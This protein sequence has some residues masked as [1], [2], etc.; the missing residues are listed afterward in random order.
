MGK[1][2]IARNEQFLLFPTVFSTR[3][4]EILGCKRCLFAVRSMPFS[5]NIAHEADFKIVK[6]LRLKTCE[7]K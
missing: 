5:D 6:T 4:G 2:E 7:K 1:G 3:L